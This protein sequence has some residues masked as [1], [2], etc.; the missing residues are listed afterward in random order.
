MKHTTPRLLLALMAVLVGTGS[1]AQGLRISPQIGVS[2]ANLPP[3]PAGPRQADH[4]V[5]V[6]NSEPITNVEVRTRLVRVEQQ[7]AQQGGVLPPRDVLAQQVLERLI[8]EKAQLQLA[9]D[10]GLKIEDSAVDQ[11]EQNVARQNQIEVAELRRRLESDGISPAS[12]RAQLRDQLTLSRL[13][14]REVEPRVRV[15]DQDVDQF[16]QEQKGIG[17]ATDMVLNLAQVLIAVPEG[18]TAAQVAERQVR[19]QQVLKRAQDGEDFAKLAREMS[20]TP[21]AARDGGQMGPREADRYPTLFVDAVKA[22]PAGGVAALVRSGAGFHVLKVLEKRQADM[23]GISVTQTHA[24]HI[25]L[26][27]SAQMPES[28]ARERL[29]D[30]KKRIEAG[31]ADFAELAREFSQD[32]SARDGGD[33]GWTNPGM[34]VP[35]FEDVLN[36]LRPG[37]LA[38]PL[39]SRFGVHLIQLLERRQ[40]TLSEREQRE[41]ARSLLRER[42]LDEA[43]VNW[44]RDVRGRAYVELRDPP[45]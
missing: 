27:V 32:G 26:R 11:A 24:R 3:I 25:L 13:R 19:A 2:R 5:A 17:S 41:I 10:T 20:D 6:V 23:P 21:G 1:Q 16:I 31:K 45:Q 15:T 7:L 28:Q 22:V 14:E 33:L 8:G 44:A 39:V 42:K 34:F 4:I 18:A 38:P 37:E 40:A 35:E 12:F 43:Y 29:G 30:F 9:R 36:S